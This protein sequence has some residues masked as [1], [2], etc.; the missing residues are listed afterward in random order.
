MKITMVGTGSAFAKRF[1]NNNALIE[2]DGYRLLVDCGI[3]LPKALHE[4]DISFHDLNAVLISH[5][6]GDHVGGLEE[7][8][9]QMMF[10]YKQKPV[11]YLAQTLIEPL[12]ENTLR[13]GLTQESLNRLDDFF[14]VKPLEIGRSYQLAPGLNVELIKTEHIIDK[15]SFSFL[16]NERF[17]Y[18]ADMRFD[19]LLLQTLVDKGVETI[20]HDCQL[21][22]PAVVHAG[23]DELLTLPKSIQEKLWLMHYGDGIDNYRG[24]TGAMRIVEQRKSYFV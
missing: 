10:K 4:M 5:I 2:V 12:W 20:Y 15:D 22:T 19:H 17:F 24:K 23:L 11:L 9:F 13:G 18:S 8:A 1:D 16:F 14:V 3:T 6:H 7:L 21:E